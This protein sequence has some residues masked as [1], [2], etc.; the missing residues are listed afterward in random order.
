MRVPAPSAALVAILVLAGCGRSEAPLQGYIEGTYVYVAPESG[1]RLVNRAASTGGRVT[2]GDLLFTLDDAD[3]RETV[4]G[5]E[6]RLAQAQ[7]QLA[8]LKT[9]QRPE[10]IAVLEAQLAQVR[11]AFTNAEE[12]FRRTSQLRQSGIVAQSAVDAAKAARDTAEAQVQAGERQLDVAKLP[13]REDAIA[14]A[15]RNVAALEASLA[16]TRI[17][18]DRRWIFSPETGVVDQTFFEPGEMIGAGQ[19]VVS[20]L[21]DA[22]RKVRFYVPEQLLPALA[23]GKTVAI[24]CD[25]CADGLTAEITYV[26]NQ[27]EFTPPIIFSRDSRE[28]LVFRVDARPLGDTMQLNVGQPVD[29]RIVAGP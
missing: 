7:S 26:S 18:L 20:L 19:P 9:G 6:A 27:A 24:T 25:R 16:Q 1:G 14:A 3:A 10:E 13:A 21:P 15:E 2:V 17:Q 12:E 5:A 29:V 23:P 4:A 11:S 22:N 28:K 8:D